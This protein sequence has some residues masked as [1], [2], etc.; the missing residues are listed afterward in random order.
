MRYIYMYFNKLNSCHLKKKKNGEM[1]MNKAK[2][3]VAYKKKLLF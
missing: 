1:V 2:K 3:R